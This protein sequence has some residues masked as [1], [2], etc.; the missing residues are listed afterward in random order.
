MLQKGYICQKM[1]QTYMD[2]RWDHII[3]YKKVCTPSIAKK[4]KAL[5]EKNAGSKI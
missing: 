4:Y 1:T 3:R 2:Y 5:L